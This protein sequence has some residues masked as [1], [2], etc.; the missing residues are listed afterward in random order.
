MRF[1]RNV[2]ILTIWPI[3]LLMSRQAEW[4][5]T[6][7]LPSLC[8]LTLVFVFRSALLGLA[9]GALAGA[10]ILAPSAWGSPLFLL[11]D[12]L[13]PALQSRWNLCVLMFTLIMGGFVGL[14]NGGGGISTLVNR[15]TAGAKHGSKR[16]EWVT[17]ALGFGCFFDGLANSMLVGSTM[18]P[19]YDRTGSPRS[20]LA[21]IVDS[22]SSPVA[23]LALLSTWIAYQ[24]SMIKEGLNA[25]QIEAN[26]YSM[27]LS[28]LP[29]NYYCWFTL[30]LVA[31]VIHRRW[32]IIST[33]SKRS[34][35]NDDIPAATGVELAKSAQQQGAGLHTVWLPLL[36]MLIMLPTSLWWSGSQALHGGSGAS[37]AQ[38]F[39]TFAAADTALMLVFTGLSTCLV[40]A[41]VYPRSAPV[42]YG[43]AF[44]G[45]MERMLAPALIL[46][47]AW[48]LSSSLKQL[49]AGVWIGQL[50]SGTVPDWFLPGLIFLAAASIS[51]LTGT[52]WG[53]MGIV[54][55]LVI[56]LAASIGSPDAAVHSTV[57]SMI[58]SVIAAAFSGAVFGDHCSP[59][60]DTTIVSSLASGIEPFEHVR[61]Q[62]PYALIAAGFALCPGFILAGVTEQLWPGLIAGLVGLVLLWFLLGKYNGKHG[63]DPKE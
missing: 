33:A 16:M 55:P 25:A 28:S 22:T 14:L 17:Y 53:T 12:L 7:V 6:P 31:I 46:V 18:R 63:E 21:Y 57:P 44:M 9:G 34:D 3:L 32:N 27:F 38:W 19:V 29:G 50:L 4:V 62:M 36:F 26:P 61:T 1:S 60:S 49:D 8:A 23:C 20:R 43:K 42:S 56:P 51:F 48:A 2:I 45:G 39:D 47:A 52:S 15:L 30:I 59:I 54:I 58:P 10:V 37:D 41:L 35:P 40:A 13:L 24:L 11:N 5:C